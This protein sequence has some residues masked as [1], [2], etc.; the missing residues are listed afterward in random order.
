[1]LSGKLPFGAN[2]YEELVVQVATQSPVPLLA[3]APHIPIAVASAV[4]RGLAQRDYRFASAEDFAMALRGALVGTV[5]SSP[6]GF[7]PTLD[8]QV[9][10]RA[11]SNRGSVRT[12]PPPPPIV[13][14]A[15]R[16]EMQSHVSLAWVVAAIGGLV[17][18]CGVAALATWRVQASR[19][20]AAKETASAATLTEAPTRPEAVVTIRPR[21]VE[22]QAV[23]LVGDERG[24]KFKFPPEVVGAVRATAVD[25]LAQGIVVQAQRCRPDHGRPPIVARVQLIVRAEGTIAIAQPATEPGDQDAAKCLAAL[26]KDAASPQTFSPGGGGVVTVEA[27]LDP[28]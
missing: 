25:A 14:T 4:D 3:I 15:S 2:T 9:V 10:P 26:F 7:E 1:M 18:I 5:P 6:H 19:V 28:R 13:T 24:V 11:D 21:A 16:R 12:A 8:A 20:D 27:K 23:T 22:T 17:A